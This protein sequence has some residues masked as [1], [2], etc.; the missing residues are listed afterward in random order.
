MYPNYFPLL[1]KLHDGLSASVL[2]RPRHILAVRLPFNH[3]DNRDIVYY[4]WSFHYNIW[5]QR[6]FS[7]SNYVSEAAFPAQIVDK[8]IIG[9]HRDWSL[10]TNDS[11]VVYLSNELMTGLVSLSIGCVIVWLSMQ[12]TIPS[13]DTNSNITGLR[14]WCD[15]YYNYPCRQAREV[16]NREYTAV[17]P[18]S[19]PMPLYYLPPLPLVGIV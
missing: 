6:G 19:A 14:G 8:Q 15:W 2:P 17:F 10:T 7:L 5:L 13:S 3:M 4:I 1:W 11:S 18:T 12:R 16:W 9:I